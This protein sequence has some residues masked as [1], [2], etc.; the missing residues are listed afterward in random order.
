MSF[1]KLSRLFVVLATI[2]ISAWAVGCGKPAADA[3]APATEE[4][5]AAEA[6]AEAGSTTG[7][8][9]AEVPEGGEE[10]AA[11]KTEESGS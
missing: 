9:G 11:P 6:P 8:A 2:S 3:P 10:P 5:P 4:A 1:T 7:G